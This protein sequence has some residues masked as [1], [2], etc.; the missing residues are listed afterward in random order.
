MA[1]LAEFKST[2][3]LAVLL[4][5]DANPYPTRQRR[6]TLRTRAPV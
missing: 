6:F 3:W 1:I 4:P 5:N 2:R